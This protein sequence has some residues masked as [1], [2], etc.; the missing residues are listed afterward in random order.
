MQNSEAP[1]GDSAAYYNSGS[2]EA[3]EETPLTLERLEPVRSSSGDD[4]KTS[5]QFYL[6]DI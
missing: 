1:A 5:M 4:G 2:K 3:A 6:M